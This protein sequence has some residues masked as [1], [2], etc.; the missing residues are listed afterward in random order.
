MLGYAS[1]DELIGRNMH[2]LCHHSHA[3]GSPYPEAE[4]PLMGTARSGKGFALAGET[5]WRADGSSFLA[6]LSVAPVIRDGRTVAAVVT[7]RDVTARLQAAREREYLLEQTQRAVAAR[8]DI[9]RIVSHDLRNPLTAVSLAAAQLLRSAPAE[10]SGRRMR[11]QATLIQR[12]AGRMQQLIDDLTDFGSIEAGKLAV[13]LAP[14]D[15]RA[16]IV[17]ACQSLQPAAQER[18]LAL[19][20]ELPESLPEI[21]CDRGRILQVLENLVANAIKVGAPGGSIT[22]G[23]EPGEREI[24]FSVTDTGPGIAADE[25]SH[26]FDRYWRSREAGYRGTGLGLA[27]SKGI[28]EAHG[29]RIGVASELGKGSRFHFTLPTSR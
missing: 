7:I 21:R 11:Q 26:L 28:I 2:R 5:L 17:D 23:A 20:S 6:D 25:L 18:G 27:I 1:S 16:L 9:V 24:E 14:E 13:N 3:D 12:A 4:C 19:R 22:L 29:G 15:P 10:E 8:E